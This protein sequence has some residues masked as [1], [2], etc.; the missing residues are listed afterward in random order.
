MIAFRENINGEEVYTDISDTQIEL[1]TDDGI[2]RMLGTN[3]IMK[4]L[5][6]KMEMFDKEKET[7]EKMAE[8]L[9]EGEAEIYMYAEDAEGDNYTISF[10]AENCAALYGQETSVF[11]GAVEMV[12]KFL[13]NVVSPDTDYLPI[14]EPIHVSTMILVAAC[15]RE[16]GKEYDDMKFKSQFDWVFEAASYEEQELPDMSD[17]MGFVKEQLA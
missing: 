3:G 17:P 8:P 11:A 14:L 1:V 9:T 7:V 5:R 12:C 10:N 6:H 13:K 16:L 15:M 2:M 4:Q